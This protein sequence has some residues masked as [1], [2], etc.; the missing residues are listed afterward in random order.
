ML[1]NIKYDSF[2][3]LNESTTCQTEHKLFFNLIKMLTNIGNNFTN[4]KEIR[5]MVNRAP[6]HIPTLV[7]S[8][9]QY[10]WLLAAGSAF[11]HCSYTLLFFYTVG[12]NFTN[13]P[14]TLNQ[15][16]NFSRKMNFHILQI[17]QILTFT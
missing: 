14:K 2:S 1:K 17:S 16:I 8:T 5:S 6:P 12:D 3:L 10:M 9:K 15:I 4:I 11:I 7:P 13:F